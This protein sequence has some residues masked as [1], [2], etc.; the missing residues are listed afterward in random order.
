VLPAAGPADVPSDPDFAST[1]RE[2]L[3]L[4]PPALTPTPAP[5]VPAAPAQP[6]PSGGQI[7]AVPPSSVLPP[8]LA[9]TPL[10]TLSDADR[11]GLPP[12]R[13]SMHVFN[14]EP[15]R[16]FVLIDGR[17]HAEGAQVSSDVVL[18]EI[19]RDG[20]VLEIRG[21]RVLIERP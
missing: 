3:P 13:L 21:R 6:D 7:A 17:R 5:I 14:D 15:Q 19:R 2:S 11:A 9:V 8:D 12:L 16:R 20:A 4:P 1:E 18:R 10:R